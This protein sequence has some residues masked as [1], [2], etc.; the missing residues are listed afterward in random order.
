MAAVRCAGQRIVIV[1][2]GAVARR[3]AEMFALHGANVRVFD[4]H[5]SP[6]EQWP[7]GVKFIR[8]RVSQRDLQNTWLVVVATN[9]AEVND[10]VGRWAAELGLEV[11]RADEVD[12][13]TFAVPAVIENPDGWQLAIL[14]GEAGPLFS[15][16]L[17]SVIKMS[18]GLPKVDQMYRA[19]ADTRLA[20]K[21]RDDLSAQQ[22][23]EVM[24]K[25]MGEALESAE[26]VNIEKFLEKILPP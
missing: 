11:N 14:G 22:R 10:R 24:R 15:T 1:G 12:A 17:K 16:W 18:L 25:V 2:G 20:L 13:G 6:E 9:D 4:P 8:R 23:S 5:V 19:L 7:E 3:R 26:P 21:G